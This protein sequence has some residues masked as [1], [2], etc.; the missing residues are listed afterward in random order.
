MN[1]DLAKINDLAKYEAYKRTKVQAQ[2][3]AE[4]AKK[5]L[6]NLLTIS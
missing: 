2:A 3:A 1:A 6:R 5:R 4:A